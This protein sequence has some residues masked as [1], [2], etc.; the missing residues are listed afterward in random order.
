L[1]D[2]NSGV[3]YPWSTLVRNF[4]GGTPRFIIHPVPQPAHV[5]TLTYVG[6]S[7]VVES[8]TLNFSS[9]F[10]ISGPPSS[11][12]QNSHGGR[13]TDEDLLARD[14]LQL[15]NLPSGAA[16]QWGE[17]RMILVDAQ[18][19]DGGWLG[20]QLQI[21]P[22]TNQPIH[23]SFLNNTWQLA[24]QIVV[25]PDL[26]PG[27]WMDAQRSYDLLGGLQQ[28]Q[29][30]DQQEGGAQP[31]PADE[32]GPSIVAGLG[33]GSVVRTD[34]PS[35]SLHV[36]DSFPGINAAS[37][38]TLFVPVGSVDTLDVPVVVDYHGTPLLARP[39]SDP[40]QLRFVFFPTWN[41]G[42]NLVLHYS[43]G[44]V[45]GFAA[46]EWMLRVTARDFSA[47]ANG[48][49]NEGRLDLP[50]QVD[51]H[52]ELAGVGSLLAGP[53]PWDPQETPELAIQFQLESPIQAG[54]AVHVF[55]LDVAGQ[56]VRHLEGTSQGIS[57]TLMWDGRN[58]SGEMVS[59]GAYLL[60]LDVKTDSKDVRMLFK[61]AVLKG[62]A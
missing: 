26:P 2:A 55:V 13:R 56:P 29:Y 48:L 61:L 37:L 51:L 19:V 21:L 20:S 27:T 49:G 15:S 32:A 31:L 30:E 62:G 44:A 17:A 54:S 45:G 3:A 50:F 59:N 38:R 47:T 57:G 34:H 41:D 18:M 25:R 33:A 11:S 10:W 12:G 22:D 52:S 23:L 28:G 36:V 53:N 14:Y 6:D 40:D 7:T 58:A 9:A 24:S 42:D 60:V 4:N 5:N 16:N 1:V 8:I 43:N 35:L 39:D 46:G